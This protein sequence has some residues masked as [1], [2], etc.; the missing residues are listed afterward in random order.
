[1]EKTDDGGYAL[2]AVS[3][4]WI[5][6]WRVFINKKGDRPGPVTNRPVAER[7]YK[8]RKRYGYKL[9]DN[10]IELKDEKEIFSLSNVFW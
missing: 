3:A 7:I 9:S 6:K 8:L 5:E 2:Y 10:H 4:E 1:M